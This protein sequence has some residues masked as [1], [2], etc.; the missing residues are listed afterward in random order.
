[1]I[2]NKPNDNDPAATSDPYT[3]GVSLT[4]IAFDQRI[5]GNGDLKDVCLLKQIW[6][7]IGSSE[8][9]I[10]AVSVDPDFYGIRWGV[11]GANDLSARDISH[12]VG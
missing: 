12:G 5:V 2:E 10:S 9:V 3:V 8:E 7:I 11:V 4:P 6:A 1:L